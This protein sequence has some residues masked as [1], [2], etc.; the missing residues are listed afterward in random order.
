MNGQ[1]RSIL[2]LMTPAFLAAVLLAL[3]CAVSAQ[4]YPSR[5]I[6]LIVPYPPGGPTDVVARLIANALPQKLHQ[7]VVV[8]NRPGGAAGTVGAHVVVSAEPDGYTLLVSQVG[9][10]TI[11][12]SLYKLDYDTQRDF[13]P[14]AILAVTP[15]ILTVHPSVPAN[16]LAEFIAYAK[17][18]PGKLNFGSPGTGTLPHI[19]GEQLQLATGIKITHVPYRGAAPAVTDLL[20]GRVQL[21]I[22]TTSVLLTHIVA[23]KLH[24][25]AISSERRVPELPNM[26]TFAEAGYPQLTESLWTGLLAPAGTPAPIIATLNAATNEI[27]KSPEVQQ[28]YARLQVG[29]KLVSPEEMKTFMADETRKWT[30]VIKAAGIKG[31]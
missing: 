12:P 7:S 28:A 6:R 8:E 29:T 4:N 16:S 19:I 5:V 13:A 3:P 22:D 17:A 23:G 11:A 15:E 27:L 25:F 9:S 14:I 20:A 26:P 30:E 1:R 31:E 10:L 2:A 24:G 18:N 21:M